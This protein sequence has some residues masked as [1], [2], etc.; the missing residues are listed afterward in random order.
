MKAN[1]ATSSAKP[2]EKT[3]SAP[4]ARARVSHREFMRRDSLKNLKNFSAISRPRKP[5][6]VKV[7]VNVRPSVKRSMKQVAAPNAGGVAGPVAAHGALAENCTTRGSHWKA[8]YRAM[9]T[10]IRA[11]SSMSNA[12]AGSAQ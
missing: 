12:L 11:C 3:I 5:A 8:R 7:W 6:R 10:M 1:P 2:K 9:H 4:P